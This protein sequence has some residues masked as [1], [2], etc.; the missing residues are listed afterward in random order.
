MT[1]RS[2]RADVRN[3]MLADPAVLAEWQELQ[4]QHPEAAAALVRMLR[5]LSKNWRAK[6]QH[7]W[8]THKAPLAAYHKANSV[9]ARHLAI[10]G[11]R[12]TEEP[13]A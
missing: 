10:A 13:L 6:A 1:T 8:T 7:A 4:R 5:A 2:N 3:P 9:N 11:A 12:G